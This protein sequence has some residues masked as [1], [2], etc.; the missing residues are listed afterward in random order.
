MLVAVV[1]G[2]LPWTP[3][4]NW[5][6]TYK[7]DVCGPK[8]WENNAAVPCPDA[9]AEGAGGTLT[10]NE[11]G[12]FDI[13]YVKYNGKSEFGVDKGYGRDFMRLPQVRWETAGELGMEL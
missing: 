4:T 3:E 1:A 6:T 8:A 7:A 2:K 5:A 9:M 12:L 13:Y 11:E 10:I